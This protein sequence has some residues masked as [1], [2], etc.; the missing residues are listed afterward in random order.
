MF[1]MVKPGV[2]WDVCMHAEP[3]RLHKAEGIPE[4]RIGPGALSVPRRLQ[5]GGVDVLAGAACHQEQPSV[6][7]RRQQRAAQSG[8]SLH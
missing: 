8:V 1:N 3:S 4:A 6:P 7:E 5:D 2:E